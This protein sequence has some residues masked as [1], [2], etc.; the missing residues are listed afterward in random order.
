MIFASTLPLL[1]TIQFQTLQYGNTRITKPYE[2]NVEVPTNL[3]CCDTLPPPRAATVYY[4]AVPPVT[5][6]NVY[7]IY[8]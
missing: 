2:P 7:R 8:C 1:N 4:V 5:T 6:C 3:T